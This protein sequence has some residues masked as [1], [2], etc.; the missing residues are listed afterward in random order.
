MKGAGGRHA[1]TW[2]SGRPSWGRGRGD[3]LLHLP[4]PARRF[5]A[6]AIAGALAKTGTA[7]LE[8][9]RM[10]LMTSATVRPPPP[11]G[12]PAAQ[13]VLK[14]HTSLETHAGSCSV[15]STA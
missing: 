13:A 7:P 12:G 2:R 3:A 5:L 9:L 8:K 15:A 1:G 4:E 11:P 10:K 14:E 6:G